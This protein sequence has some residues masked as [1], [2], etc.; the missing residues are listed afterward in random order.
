[1]CLIVLCAG[2]LI[3]ND[4]SRMQINPI[5]LK[6]PRIH[7]SNH[8]MKSKIVLIVTFTAM[9]WLAILSNVIGKPV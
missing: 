4:D 6:F 3:T 2:D 9:A 8:I 5:N 7:K 1:M